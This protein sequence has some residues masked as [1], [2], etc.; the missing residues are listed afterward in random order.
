MVSLLK[1]MQEP[2]QPKYMYGH[3]GLAELLKYLIEMQV[4]DVFKSGK[5]VEQEKG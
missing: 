4:A 1:K 2:E 5:A 3:K